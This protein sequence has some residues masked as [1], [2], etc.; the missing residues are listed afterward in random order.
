MQAGIFSFFSAHIWNT[1]WSQ[2]DHDVTG[3]NAY[4]CRPFFKDS[5]L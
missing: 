3:Q 4:L 1:L 2:Q 5:E